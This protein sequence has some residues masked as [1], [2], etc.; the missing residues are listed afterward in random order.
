MKKLLILLFSLLVSF[1][2]YGEW[3]EIAEGAKSSDI[4][5]VDINSIRERNGY[6]YW[7]EMVDYLKPSKFGHMSDKSYG[8]VDCNSM[9]YQYLQMTFYKHSKGLGETETITPTSGW[10]YAPPDSTA[11]K[12]LDYV[13]DYVK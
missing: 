6:V 5:Y 11:G 8:Y 3:K 13:C 7:W 2:S 12:L 4:T 1:N 10:H 9:S